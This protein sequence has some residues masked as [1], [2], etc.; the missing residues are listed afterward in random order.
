MLRIESALVDVPYRV[1]YPRGPMKVPPLL[2]G[3]F[4]PRQPVESP[5][6]LQAAFFYGRSCLLLHNKEYTS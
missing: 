4:F 2:S 6:S 5:P 3:R 1:R